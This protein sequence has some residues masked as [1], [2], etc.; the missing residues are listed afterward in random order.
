MLA[1]V[2]SPLLEVLRISAD[3]RP[4]FDPLER[5]A[6]QL[7]RIDA[8]EARALLTQLTELRAAR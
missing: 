8:Q 4:A 7:E 5:M 2:R 6:H 1:Q 3:F